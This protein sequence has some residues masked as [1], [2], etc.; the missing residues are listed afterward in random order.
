MRASTPLRLPRRPFVV[1]GITAAFCMS[2]P[3][4]AAQTTLTQVKMEIPPV[5]GR[6]I[7]VGPTDPNQ[8]LHLSI[9]MPYADA[10]GMQAFVD[11]V[12][13]PKN[14]LYR[15]FITPEQVGARF[16]LPQ[17]TVD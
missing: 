15:Q 5:V 17:S 11:A 4:V 14:P 13:D 6:S 2:I 12:S 7:L 10:Q 9:A 3:L 1:A 8:V 16:G